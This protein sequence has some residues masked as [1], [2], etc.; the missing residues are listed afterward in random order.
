MSNTP[1][2]RIVLVTLAAVAVAA[3]WAWPRRTRP[4]V[5]EP[6]DRVAP[7]AAV[8][9]P[10]TP[11]PSPQ[12]SEVRAKIDGL[13][14]PVAEWAHGPFV[15]GDFNGDG[16]YDLAAV[17]RPRSDRVQ[18]LNDD[19]ANWIV[20]DPVAAASIPPGSVPPRPSLG[21]EPLLVVVH[22]F[23]AEGWRSPAARQTYV[24]KGMAGASLEA[25]PLRAT[26]ATAGLVFPDGRTGDVVVEELAGEP[27]F[28]YWRGARYVWSPLR[29]S[30]PSS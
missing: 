1:P 21:A 14:G 17:V 26:A 2:L 28:L 20:Q 18:D 8:A 10:A 15:A 11:P 23:D 4:P 12:P 22:G 27:G 29:R 9:T 24:L 7:V 16:W 3:V 13:F 5:E 30:S 6:P 19:L 25:R